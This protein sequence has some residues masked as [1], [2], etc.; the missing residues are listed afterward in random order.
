MMMNTVGNIAGAV[1]QSW[2]GIP[3]TCHFATLYWL[4]ADEFNNAITTQA[5]YLNKFP[6]PTAVISSLLPFGRKLSRP[7]FGNLNLVP[8]NILV[9]AHGMNAGHSCVALNA[10]TIGGYNQDGWFSQAGG[11]HTYTTHPTSQIVWRGITHPKDVRRPNIATNY[12]LVAI[13]E[14]TAKAK[15]RQLAQN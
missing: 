12:N 1:G 11:N 8:G 10:N 2:N 6:N 7:A 3:T 4:Y 9:F 15:I 13:D 14:N 5:D